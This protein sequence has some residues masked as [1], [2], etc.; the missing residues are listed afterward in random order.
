MLRPKLHLVGAIGLVGVALADP[1]DFVNPK[2]VVAAKGDPV[3]KDARST[4]VRSGNTAAQ[5]GPWTVTDSSIRAS[6]N[7]PH[8]YLSWAP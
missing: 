2:Y 4:I 8:D 6:S 7:D 5:K 3:T 1:N